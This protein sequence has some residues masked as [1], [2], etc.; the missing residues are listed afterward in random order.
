MFCYPFG[1]QV[2]NHFVPKQYIN[3]T[4]NCLKLGGVNNAII[5][6]NAT[7][8]GKTKTKQKGGKHMVVGKTQIT[9][10]YVFFNCI[11]V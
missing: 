1:I 3:K 6:N 10:C 8:N 9:V 2:S 11:I 5:T 4:L 7:A